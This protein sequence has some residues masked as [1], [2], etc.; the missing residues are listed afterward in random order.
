MQQIPLDMNQQELINIVK[1][2]HQ[3]LAIAR[4]LK[5]TESA[6]RVEAYQNGVNAK[7]QEELAAAQAVYDLKV[8][9]VRLSQKRS[10][11]EGVEGVRQELSLE[12]VKHETNLD[13]ALIAAYNGN[14]PI[15]RIALDGFGNRYDGGVQQ[16]LSK[17]RVDGRIGNREDYQRNTEESR[18]ET[19]FPRVIDFENIL[20]EAL[21][22]GAPTYTLIP[23]DLVLVEP[24]A[25]GEDGIS[26]P[27]VR[28]DMDPRDPW[29][30]QVEANARPGTPFV[31][32]TYCTLYE[33]PSTGMIVAHESR[34]EGQ[35][36][37]DHPVAR[38]A[39]MH[40]GRV[41]EGFQ[42]AVSTISAES[43]E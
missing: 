10:L 26:V 2:A 27:A 22:I 40:S 8:S 17:L 28:L 20:G 21:T 4:K 42:S 16:L 32:A 18:A 13:N 3:T 43:S 1:S 34:E 15:R 36:L 35:T 30:R 9:M 14:I 31:R 38:W 37:W 23:V 11:E 5:V 6:R 33:H 19:S 24:N 12:I 29:F 7:A 41:E 39:K 25:D